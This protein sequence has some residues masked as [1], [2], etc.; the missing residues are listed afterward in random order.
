MLTASYFV[1]SKIDTSTKGK[2]QLKPIP[3]IKRMLLHD[4]GAVQ[5]EHSNHSFHNLY[6][7]INPEYLLGQYTMLPF[8][9][10]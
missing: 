1:Q 4:V 6:N 3:L 7:Q 9:F 2:N 5:R 8:T 10:S